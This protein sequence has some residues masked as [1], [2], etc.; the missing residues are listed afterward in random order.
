MYKHAKV[1]PDSFIGSGRMC[2][3]FVNGCW[4]NQQYIVQIYSTTAISK[5]FMKRAPLRGPI[6]DSCVRY[7]GIWVLQTSLLK[8]EIGY[9]F[10]IFLLFSFFV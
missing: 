2:H 3:P 6:S 1:D 4:D 9:G 7:G 8:L 5:P 10:S